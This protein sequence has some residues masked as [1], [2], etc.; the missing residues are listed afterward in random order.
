MLCLLI[1]NFR[2]NPIFFFSNFSK[3]SIISIL[4]ESDWKYFL[5]LCCFLWFFIRYSLFW[6]YN[7]W[8][9]SENIIIVYQE[10]FKWK[11]HL[12]KKVFLSSFTFLMYIKIDKLTFFIKKPLFFGERYDSSKF[13]EKYELQEQIGKVFFQFFF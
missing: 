9:K 1:W 12:K 2:E 7:S 13:I 8:Y 6:C 10:I 3:V 5:L 4:S 11:K